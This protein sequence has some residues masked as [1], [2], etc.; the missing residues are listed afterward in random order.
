MA[1]RREKARVFTRKEGG[2]RS[3][4]I[5][6]SKKSDA[7]LIKRRSPP[8]LLGTRVFPTSSKFSLIKSWSDGRSVSRFILR[9]ERR[10]S[11]PSL[12]FPPPRGKSDFF[13]PIPFVEAIIPSNGAKSVHIAAWH[14]LGCYNF[15]LPS[16][17][18][19]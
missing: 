4:R 16:T 17:Q 7:S 15:F 12:P 14:S 6:P 8:P 5:R 19:F 10:P 13:Q 11:S 18:I 3:L 9:E 1:R 2:G